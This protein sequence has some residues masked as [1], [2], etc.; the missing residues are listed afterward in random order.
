MALRGSI[1]TDKQAVDAFLIVA[2]INCLSSV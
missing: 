2:N 1:M